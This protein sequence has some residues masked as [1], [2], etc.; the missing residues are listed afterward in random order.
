MTT[1]AADVT[2]N[3]YD[4]LM[5]AHSY[6]SLIVEGKRPAITDHA[7]QVAR[8]RLDRIDAALADAADYLQGGT[9]A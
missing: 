9:D 6:V 3:L 7:R 5:T 2:R 8:E 1:V 4:A